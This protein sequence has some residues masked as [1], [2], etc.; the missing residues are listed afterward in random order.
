MLPMKD[1]INRPTFCWTPLITVAG[2]CAT[3]RVRS[4]LVTPVVIGS[5]G[6]ADDRPTGTGDTGIAAVD[7]DG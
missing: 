6:Q 3:K 5:D 1:N 7:D 2:S 4:V